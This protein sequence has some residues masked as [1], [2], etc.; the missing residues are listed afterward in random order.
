MISR[1]MGKNYLEGLL[2]IIAVLLDLGS[3][4]RSICRL[5]SRDAQIILMAITFEGAPS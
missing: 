2:F 3:D 1:I 4:H 5:N